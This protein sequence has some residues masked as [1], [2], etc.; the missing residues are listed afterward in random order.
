[1]GDNVSY[2]RSGDTAMIT[3]DDGKV[4]AMSIATMTTINAALDQAG[5]HGCILGVGVRHTYRRSG[6]FHSWF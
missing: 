4:N 6:C 2:S 5:R 3:M 1:M